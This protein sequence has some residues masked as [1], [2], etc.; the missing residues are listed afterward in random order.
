[1]TKII[2]KKC[3]APSHAREKRKK[4]V[5]GE[6]KNNVDSFIQRLLSTKKNRLFDFYTYRTAK[7]E[8]TLSKIRQ[9]LHICGFYQLL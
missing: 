1:M 8:I 2:L 3:G 6:N 5:N 9:Y 4:N 7:R